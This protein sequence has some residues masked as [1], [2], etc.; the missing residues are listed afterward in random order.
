M[1]AAEAK[2]L[3][4]PQMEAYAVI[5]P[6]VEKVEVAKQRKTSYRPTLSQIRLPFRSGTKKPTLQSV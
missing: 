1:M 5:Q 4:L 6:K 2:G 3:P